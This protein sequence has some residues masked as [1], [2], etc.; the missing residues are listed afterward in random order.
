MHYYASSD[1]APASLPPGGGTGLV[2]TVNLAY[3]SKSYPGQLWGSS[4]HV[5]LATL[6]SRLLGLGNAKMF[7]CT[8]S[9]GVTPGSYLC[10]LGVCVC[11][12]YLCDR[13]Q[14]KYDVPSC[15]HG[16]RSSVIPL[17]VRIL[18]IRTVVMIPRNRNLI[19]NHTTIPSINILWSQIRD[20]WESRVV[21]FRMKE[22][23]SKMK[24]MLVRMYSRGRNVSETRLMT[25]ISIV[26]LSSWKI[27]S[28]MIR[29]R[30]IH[31]T[32]ICTIA[33]RISRIVVQWFVHVSESCVIGLSIF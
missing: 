5:G 26:R 1:G 6:C 31:Y 22:S 17:P 29:I 28:I 30:I 18:G 2:G 21:E 8:G 13:T 16:M 3:L 14:R 32:R 9:P 33:V 20:M 24:R 25:R 15:V 10:I 4:N 27:C 11:E 12:F 19:W 7:L 23:S